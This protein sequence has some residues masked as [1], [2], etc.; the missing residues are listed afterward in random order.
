MERALAGLP[1][2]LKVSYRREVDQFGVEYD[3]NETRL[4]ELTAAVRRTVVLPE[5]RRRLGGEV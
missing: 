4:A 2:V 1:G 5:V 3:E